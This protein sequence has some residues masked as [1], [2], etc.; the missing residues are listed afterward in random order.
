MSYPSIDQLV[1][2][3]QAGSGVAVIVEG[4]SAREDAWFFK[5]WF[6]GLARQVTFFPQD[7]W[8]AVTRAVGELR[9]LLPHMPIY[10][11]MDR[12]F[13]DDDSVYVHGH[14]MMPADG[15]LRM[16]R[17]NLENYLFE[18]EGWVTTLRQVMR[19]EIIPGWSK[20]GELQAKFD[21]LYERYLPV[22]AYNSVLAHLERN[23]GVGLVHVGHPNAIHERDLE[24]HFR[25]LAHA[26]GL[27]DDLYGLFRGRLAAYEALPTSDRSMVVDGKHVLRDFK[28]SL[29]SPFRGWPED[30]LIS[31]YM[32]A[33]PEA[34]VELDQLVRFVL[35]DAG[36]K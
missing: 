21:E 11:I 18:P 13:I 12:D 33:R 4:E 32:S 17:R 3:V 36:S 35:A 1:V 10:G 28:N 24:A 30:S 16:P 31:L 8:Q 7:G 34:P 19:G 25:E 6:G 15:L 22:A 27:T 5:Q 14:T 23:Y 9:R 2:S 26:H 20:H 29:P